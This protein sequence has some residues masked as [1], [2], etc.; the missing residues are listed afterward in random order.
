MKKLQMTTLAEAKVI[1]TDLYQSLEDLKSEVNQRFEAVQMASPEAVPEIDM[2]QVQAQID[3]VADA[4]YAELQN[5]LQE[6]VNE[7]LQA[8]P[9]VSDALTW[10]EG[11]QKIKS[12][13]VDLHGQAVNALNHILGESGHELAIA[14]S[15]TVTEAEEPEAVLANEKPEL[16]YLEHSTESFE[17]AEWHE[18][19]QRF[20]RIVLA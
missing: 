9:S 10:E 16:P 2:S 11:L 17:G 4:K 3:E 13:D 6:M 8:N 1:I 20:E 12:G 7:A 15:R 19:R 5:Q 14:P 18:G